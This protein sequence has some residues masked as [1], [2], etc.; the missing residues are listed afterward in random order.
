MKELKGMIEVDSKLAG[1]IEVLLEA[2]A[3][4]K[5]QDFIG[6]QL[7]EQAQSFLGNIATI[8]E[9]QVEFAH[10]VERYKAA[11]VLKK[12]IVEDDIRK[13]IKSVAEHIQNMRIQI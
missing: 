1:L 10:H 11:N 6:K 5:D 2:Q 7:A 9:Y 12:K 8:Q 3:H 13:K 4:L